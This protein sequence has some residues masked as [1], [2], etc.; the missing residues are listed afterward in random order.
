M[1][2]FRSGDLGVDKMSKLYLQYENVNE[3]PT[4]LY[5]ESAFSSL[6]MATDTTGE[7]G[8]ARFYY[9]VPATAMDPANEASALASEYWQ[10]YTV[11]C[12]VTGCPCTLVLGEG[13]SVQGNCYTIWGTG[14]V[15]FVS[16]TLLVLFS[17]F[18]CFDKGL[19]RLQLL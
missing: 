10:P 8:G 4:A 12:A 19:Y 3:Y 13:E 1:P 6:I 14:V 9:F 17:R 7:D 2:G 5:Y 18:R 15:P 11:W 16:W